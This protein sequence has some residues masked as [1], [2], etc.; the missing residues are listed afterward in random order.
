MEFWGGGGGGGETQLEGGNP[1]APP[2]P[3]PPSVCNPGVPEKIIKERTGHRSTD[4]LH[5][6]EKKSQNQHQAVSQILSSNF[7]HRTS[8]IHEMKKVNSSP[9]ACAQL[10]YF[11]NL[12][13]ST[14]HNIQ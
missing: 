9:F 5:V 7:K 14:S 1:S 13:L 11:N 3:P 8:Y 10:I 2:P 6:Y 4:G 12:K